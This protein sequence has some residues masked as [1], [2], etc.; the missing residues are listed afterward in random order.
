[1]SP[2]AREAEAAL[3]QHRVPLCSRRVLHV[4]CGAGQL[5]ALVHGRC[6]AEVHGVWLGTD[7]AERAQAESRAHRVFDSVDAAGAAGC[8]YDCIVVAPDT[9]AAPL[10][11]L[12]GM[13]GAEGFLV[14]RR[15]AGERGAAPTDLVRYAAWPLDFPYVELD[16]PFALAAEVPWVEVFTRAGYDPLKHAQALAGQRLFER[17]YE[18]LCAIAPERRAD[19]DFDVRIQTLKMVCLLGLHKLGQYPPLTCLAA[20]LLLFSRIQRRRPNQPEVLRVL[21]R[22]WDAAGDAGTAARMLRISDELAGASPTPAPAASASVPERAPESFVVPSAAPR[23]LFVMG[24]PRVNYGLDVLYHG[25]K[26]VLGEERVCE[27]PF[28][29]TLHGA[30]DEKFGHYP[31]LF[32]HAGT[33]L[34]AEEVLAQVRAGRF[35][36]VFWGDTEQFLPTALAR[37]IFQAAGTSRVALVDMQD[38]CADHWQVLKAAYGLEMLP[39]CFKRER[40]RAVQYSAPTLP[41]PFAYPDEMVAMDIDH[42]RGTPL[43][44]AGQRGWGLRDVFLPV[45]E[46]RGI[47]TAHNFTQAAYRAALRDARVCL[48]LGGAGFDT[49]RYWEAPAQGALLLSETLPILLPHD[50]EDMRDAVFFTTPAEMGERLDFLAAHPEVLEEMRHAGWTRLRTH[51]TA[52]A[53][54]LQLLATLEVGAEDGG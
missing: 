44:W 54:A 6:G 27:F 36:V 51:H 50:F 18:I 25:L 46:A 4:D 13:L 43:F 28:K 2:D 45:L 23:V 37:E 34:A 3:L 17:A 21:A 32:A 40:L 7:P 24:E 41:L 12:A 49:V 22:F 42:A 38:D 52:T 19:V 8:T 14:L 53:R 33:P 9:D 5:C 47:P 10:D 16:E 26:G 15:G 29:P 39:R 1:M 20:G 30:L 31:C 48:S 11:I 35:D